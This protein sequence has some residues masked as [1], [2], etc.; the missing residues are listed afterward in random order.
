MEITGIIV[1]IIILLFLF[2]YKFKKS[3]FSIRRIRP[4]P[5]IRRTSVAT[6]NPP[7]TANPSQNQVI[8][9]ATAQYLAIHGT[10]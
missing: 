8:S 4:A 6:V 2:L 3:N 5:R 10:N 9:D 7:P 1:I